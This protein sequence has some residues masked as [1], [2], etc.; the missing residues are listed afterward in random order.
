MIYLWLFIFCDHPCKLFYM[1]DHESHLFA[2]VYHEYSNDNGEIWQCLEIRLIL[3]SKRTLF[4]CLNPEHFTEQKTKKYC[5]TVVPSVADDT[6]T[7][8]ESSDEDWCFR[9]WY[10]VKTTT[11]L[12]LKCTMIPLSCYLSR[13]RHKLSVRMHVFP[14]N[15]HLASII[16]DRRVSQAWQQ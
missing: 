13:L 16:D 6:K 3:S 8:S 10:Y 5:A 4:V 11:L 14:Q 2:F 15:P 9:C 1:T 12:R 7:G